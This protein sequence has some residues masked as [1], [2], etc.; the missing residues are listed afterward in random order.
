M[1]FLITTLFYATILLKI[2][3]KCACSNPCAANKTEPLG[4]YWRDYNGNIP[5]DAVK[6]GED[7]KGNPTYIGQVYTKSFELL[8]ATIYQGCSTV[9][10][11]AYN[12]RL[13]TDKNIKILCSDHPEKLSWYII[14]NDEMHLLTQCHLLVG[15]SEVN[16]FLNI[17]RVNYDGQIII[18]KVFRIKMKLLL[19]STL[20][21]TFGWRFDLCC[22]ERVAPG[23]YWR[24]YY[25]KI[26]SDAVQG[27]LDKQGNPTYIGQVYI[28][29]FE[30]LPATIYKESKKAVTSAYNIRMEV[31]K[32]I[33]ILCSDEKEGFEW[34]ATKNEE[35]HLMVNCH[36]VVGGSEVGQTLNIGRVNSDGETIIGKV[37]SHPLLNRGLWV[38]QKSGAAHFLTYEILT[39]GC[40]DFGI[41]VRSMK[42]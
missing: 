11:S 20:Y 7:R 39:Y 31:D 2:S 19:I 4:Y 37:F 15:G 27:G 35:T 5:Y 42:L 40:N 6:G 10:F 29:G 41:D 1:K 36:L 34:R 16:E 22:S 12:K 18:G 21:M 24:D 17:G 9:V 23:Y 26:P 38:P 13:E 14:K 33:K 8:P 25:G 32:D 30:L 28:K 3:V